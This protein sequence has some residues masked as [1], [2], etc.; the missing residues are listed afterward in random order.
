MQMFVYQPWVEVRAER[1][2]HL[3]AK[4][5]RPRSRGS[6]RLVSRDPRSR[7]DIRLN[8]MADPEDMRRMADGVRLMLALAESPMLAEHTT[9]Q[10]RFE[11]GSLVSLQE[12]TTVLSSQEAVERYIRQTVRHYVHPVGSARMG[13]AGDRDAVVD[14]HCR[15][16]GVDRLR[17][18][19]ASV[20]PNIPR[21]N[22]NLTCI[23]IGERV[24]DWMRTE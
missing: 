3:T 17:V 16:W 2:T 9:R 13:P 21:A 15:V 4:L 14:Q 8:L 20:M 10:I 7:P 1:V 24:A 22:T 11:D 18:V 5:M 23:M 19:D 6:L 12:A